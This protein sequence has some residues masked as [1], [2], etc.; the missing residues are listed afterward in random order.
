MGGG[1]ALQLALRHPHAVAGAFVFS[2]PQKH[3]LIGGSGDLHL[4]EIG[5]VGRSREIYLG[6]RLSPCWIGGFNV[7][8][9]PYCIFSPRCL[10]LEAKP[11]DVC[12]YIYIYRYDLSYIYMVYDL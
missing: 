2:G 1:I 5:Q 7:S 12:E 10:K 6:E 9:F 4:V 11:K 3:D 8:Q